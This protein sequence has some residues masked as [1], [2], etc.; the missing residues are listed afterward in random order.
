[1]AV[2]KH[3]TKTYFSN[4]LVVCNKMR[5]FWDGTDIFLTYKSLCLKKNDRDVVVMSALLLM[6]QHQSL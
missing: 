1:M 5:Y 3:T 4:C 6:H 2:V